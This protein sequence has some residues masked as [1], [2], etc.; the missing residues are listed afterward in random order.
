MSGAQST[1]DKEE[2][3]LT[4][5]RKQTLKTTVDLCLLQQDKDVKKEL[6]KLK[7]LVLVEPDKPAEAGTETK[8]E[9][10][11]ATGKGFWNVFSPAVVPSKDTVDAGIEVSA[12]KSEAK[13]KT[14]VEKLGKKS[15]KATPKPLSQP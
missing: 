12:K 8:A 15:S 2:H 11:A 13:T 1:A 3:N 6:D 14:P 9:P 4:E 5:E 7:E 10:K